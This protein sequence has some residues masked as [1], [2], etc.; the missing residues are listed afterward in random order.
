MEVPLDA[1]YW[2]CIDDEHDA[3]LGM[4]NG[5][6]ES[7]WESNY[8]VTGSYHKVAFMFD[9]LIFRDCSS[10]EHT[11]TLSKYDDIKQRVDFILDGAD[12]DDDIYS[13]MISTLDDASAAE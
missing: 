9:K 11:G 2:S 6:F 8:D 13:H 7:V 10:L 4:W 12:V 1:A 5:L 3:A